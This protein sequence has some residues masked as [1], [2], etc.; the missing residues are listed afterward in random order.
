MERYMSMEPTNKLVS[1]YLIVPGG[2]FVFGGIINLETNAITSTG[3]AAVLAQH[4]QL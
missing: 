1:Y 3:R 2:T 4:K